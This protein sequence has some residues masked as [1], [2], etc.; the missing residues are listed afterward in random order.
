MFVVLQ[1]MST[2][3]GFMSARGQTV[4]AIDDRGHIGW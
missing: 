1:Q 4:E 3:K 2:V